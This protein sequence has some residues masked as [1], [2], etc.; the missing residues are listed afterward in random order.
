MSFWLGA[1]PGASV[2][3]KY[4]SLLSYMVLFSNK[5]IGCLLV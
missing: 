1:L 3:T 2:V 4:Q 5:I